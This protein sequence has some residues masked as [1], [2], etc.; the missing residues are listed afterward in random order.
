MKKILF[1]TTLF[2]TFICAKLNQSTAQNLT[3]Q[4]T[5]STSSLRLFRD[6]TVQFNE[7]TATR[8]GERVYDINGRVI[9][10]R[11]SG[12][13]TDISQDFNSKYEYTSDANGRPTLL[14]T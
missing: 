14:I 11:N 6:I 2:L 10:S 12:W 5:Q 4:Q 3:T 7:N 13:N 8:K 9:S 1:I